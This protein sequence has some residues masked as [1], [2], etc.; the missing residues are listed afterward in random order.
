MCGWATRF[1]SPCAREVGRR[2]W[3]DAAPRA[4]H[5]PDRHELVRYPIGACVSVAYFDERPRWTIVSGVLL[6]GLIGFI[7]YMVIVNWNALAPGTRIYPGLLA[8][9]AI[10]GARRALGARRHRLVFTM[11]DRT[12]LTWVSRPDE[13]E[14]F[15]P[16]AERV[17]EFA[18]TREL[19][20]NTR[21]VRTA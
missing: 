18:R 4:L 19:L 3:W 13:F 6:V 5:A 16:S 2:P 10:Y 7:G 20:A 11:K 12:R 17:V 9:L 15:A 8:L 21:L 14:V 1:G